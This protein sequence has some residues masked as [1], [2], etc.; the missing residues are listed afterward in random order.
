MSWVAPSRCWDI[1]SWRG[2]CPSY[3]VLLRERTRN[4]LFFCHSKQQLLMATTHSVAVS[5]RRPFCSHSARPRVQRLNMST[6]PLAARVIGHGV[7]M[8]ALATSSVMS[9][10]G[11]RYITW[12]LAQCV[13]KQTAMH[14]RP[15]QYD[16][17]SGLGT[18]SATSLNRSLPHLSCH[19]RGKAWRSRVL[20]RTKDSSHHWWH[21]F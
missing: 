10:P 4:R 2:R 18:H 1:I 5:S 12:F 21:H 6:A 19:D 11:C 15:F 8:A 9:G 16:V 17:T 7:A 14:T 13:P 20:Y 3:H